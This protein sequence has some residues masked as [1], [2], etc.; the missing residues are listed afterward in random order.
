MC[1]LVLLLFQV[2]Q[3]QVGPRSKKQPNLS[4]HAP[5]DRTASE[6]AQLASEIG[7]LSMELSELKEN[8][9]DAKVKLGESVGILKVQLE[10]MGSL[11]AQ[12]EEARI[13]HEA[14]TSA[15]TAVEEANEMAMAQRAQQPVETADLFSWGAP[16]AL[17]ATDHPTPNTERANKE[18]TDFVDAHL[19]NF[20]GPFCIAKELII[21]SAIN[22]D[23]EAALRCQLENPKCNTN[24]S[25]P[26]GAF[27]NARAIPNYFKRDSNFLFWREDISKYHVFGKDD[28]V[29]MEDSP[30]PPFGNRSGEGLPLL[31]DNGVG[32]YQFGH[33]MNLL[34]GLITLLEAETKELDNVTVLVDFLHSKHPRWQSAVIDSLVAD[35]VMKSSWAHKRE[36]NDTRELLLRVPEHSDNPQ[37]SICFGNSMKTMS[38]EQLWLHPREAELFQKAIRRAYPN[39]APKTDSCP[40][41]K[42][43]V[44]YRSGLGNQMRKILNYNAVEEALLD[45]GIQNYT[46]ETVAQHTPIEEV[47][48]LFSSAGLI[49]S[50]HSSQMKLLVFAHPDTVVVEVRSMDMVKFSNPFGAG[51]NA[52]PVHYMAHNVHKAVVGCKT[53]EVCEMWAQK[54]NVYAD[55]MVNR[56]RL[57]SSIAEG[58]KLQEKRCPIW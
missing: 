43:I 41:P 42:A 30:P 23:H 56:S 37:N 46:N 36:N 27:S 51:L 58:L 35:V 7:K 4:T 31:L 40:P 39:F 14:L 47:I 3:Y 13:T 28:G 25:F 45:N 1:I 17:E 52:L 29:Y 34:V 2:A 10:K 38:P 6:S 20:S 50:T 24:Y 9:M 48:D 55:V 57:A 15:N 44:M 22:H 54:G 18:W 49:I 21:V 8:V 53:P 33:T 19:M 16:A 11:E 5:T 12:V 26:T 32:A